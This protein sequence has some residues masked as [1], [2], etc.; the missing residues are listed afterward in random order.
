MEFLT[1]GTRNP[2]E[3]ELDLGPYLKTCNPGTVIQVFENLIKPDS[4]MTLTTLSFLVLFGD[5]V[6]PKSKQDIF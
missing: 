4:V 2:V 1:V 6:V 5:Y 3:K